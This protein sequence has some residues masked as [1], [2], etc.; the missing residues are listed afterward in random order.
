M[1]NIILIIII[2]ICIFFIAISIIKHKPDRIVNFLLRACVG[3]AGICLLDFLLGLGGYNINVGLNGITIL[4]NG[5]LG[6]PG[7]IMLYGL[8][9]YYSL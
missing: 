7:F 1:E 2:A 9:Y 5:L 8:A 6:L 4:S 3:T